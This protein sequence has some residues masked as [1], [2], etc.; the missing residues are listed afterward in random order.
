MR[1]ASIHGNSV[2]KV[3]I[4]EIKII[5]S[6]EFFHVPPYSDSPSVLPVIL[7]PTPSA[8]LRP[9]TCPTLGF[10]GVVGIGSGNVT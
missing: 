2:E 5:L 1:I 8:F 9:Q 10:V 6:F 7:K 4:S 3:S